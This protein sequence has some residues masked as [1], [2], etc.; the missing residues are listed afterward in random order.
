MDA[1]SV[2]GVLS[3]LEDGIHVLQGDHP[4]ALLLQATDLGDGV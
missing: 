3:L 4:L 1:T 2:L